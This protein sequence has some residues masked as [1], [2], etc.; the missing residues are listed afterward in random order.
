[1]LYFFLGYIVYNLFLEALDFSSMSVTT[2]NVVSALL[3]LFAGTPLTIAGAMAN[4]SGK[5]GF[6]V[7]IIQFF[8]LSYLLVFFIGLISSIVL[9]YTD[10]E[11]KVEIARW[12]AVVSP[13]QLLTI[14]VVFGLAY[15][16]EMY[17]DR[18]KRK[19]WEKY[20]HEDWQKDDH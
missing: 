12:V 9:L 10:I 8:T 2:I 5:G 1:M 6:T 3:A 20:D 4:D 14:V 11:N 15:L 16:K 7:G 13:L 17:D 19:E 18:Q